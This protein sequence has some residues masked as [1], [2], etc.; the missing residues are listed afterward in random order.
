MRFY[1]FMEVTKKEKKKWKL[2]RK[3]FYLLNIRY[4]GKFCR[5]KEILAIFKKLLTHIS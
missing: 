2:D 3:L 1:T 4:P 5:E